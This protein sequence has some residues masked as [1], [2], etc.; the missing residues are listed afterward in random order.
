M[1]TIKNEGRIYLFASEGQ[2][3]AVD[4]RPGADGKEVIS[5]GHD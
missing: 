2:G 5:W 4:E 1:G 3:D